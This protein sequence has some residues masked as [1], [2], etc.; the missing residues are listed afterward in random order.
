MNVETY[1]IQEVSEQTVD[2]NEE[3]TKIMQELKLEGQEK[4]YSDDN[5]QEVSGP[6]CYRKMTAQEKV[7]IETVCPRKSKLKNYGEGPIPLRVLQV[8]AHVAELKKEEIR[9][10]LGILQIWHPENADDPDPYLIYRHG[11]EY[12]SNAF[13]LLARWGDELDNWNVLKEKARKIL[14]AKLEKKFVEI[15]SELEGSLACI[16]SK[17]T[18][19]LETGNYSEPYYSGR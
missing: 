10:E 3:C 1:E 5:Q 9:D 8:A 11:K 15:K 4:F 7:V 13:F 16:D 14:R 12:S 6:F 2:K 18:L 19:A 17:I